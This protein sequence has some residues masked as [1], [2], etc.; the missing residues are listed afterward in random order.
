MKQRVIDVMTI[1]EGRGM[2]E[3]PK[4]LGDFFKEFPDKK[5]HIG[6]Q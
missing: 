5:P 4:G 2:P 1:K 3:V 6:L